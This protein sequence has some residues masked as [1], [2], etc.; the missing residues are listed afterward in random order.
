MASLGEAI[1]GA[2]G[3]PASVRIGQVDSVF[4]LVISAEGVPFEDVGLLGSYGPALGDVVALVGQSTAAGSD[5]AS[6]LALGPLTGLGAAGRGISGTLTAQ[7]NATLNLTSAVQSVGG[8]SVTFTTARP[9]AVVLASWTADFEVI[10]AAATTGVCF[11]YVDG[12]AQAHQ[13]L[14]QMPVA[15]ALG[16]WTCGQTAVVQLAAAGAHTIN[17][18]GQRVGGADNQIRL[19]PVHTNWSGLLLQ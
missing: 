11:M 13:A 4:P 12:V 18:R 8:T 17:L 16:R 9:G 19:N 14:V 6:W 15:A 5:P 10:A 3:Q 7:S 1:Q 2:V